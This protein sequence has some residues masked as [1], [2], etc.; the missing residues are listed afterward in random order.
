M[1]WLLTAVVLGA[2]CWMVSALTY[3]DEGAAAGPSR[4]LDAGRASLPRL[5]AGVQGTLARW[6][7]VSRAALLRFVRVVGP[8]IIVAARATATVTVRA[9]RTTGSVLW[10]VLRTVAIA[11][12]RSA[13]FAA[14]QAVRPWN[15]TRSVIADL[16]RAR[17][18][19]QAPARSAQRYHVP[20]EKS[21]IL[22]G[23]QESAV[24]VALPT[25]SAPARRP[26][27]LTR[28]LTFIQLVFLVVL[29]GSGAALAIAGAAWAVTRIV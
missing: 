9:L 11:V 17:T 1:Q 24:G 8:P 10:F 21:L 7:G 23:P 18:E 14:V 13:R 4:L 12:A 20:F 19:R 26:S 29:W 5:A 27:A 6:A 3:Q 15:A 2:A 22:T 16:R 25:F 28:L